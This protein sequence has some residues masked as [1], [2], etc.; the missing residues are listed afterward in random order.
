MPHANKLHGMKKQRLNR[1]SSIGLLVLIGLAAAWVIARAIAPH[2]REPNATEAPALTQFG[3]YRPDMSLREAFDSLPPAGGDEVGLS[4][5]PENQRSW[6]ARWQMLAE[7]RQS[8]DISY[9]ILREDIFG[10]AFLGHLLR[11]AK[12]GLHVRLLL[13]RQGTVMSFTSKLGLDWLDTLANTRRIDIKVF[14][15]LTDRYLQA[16]AT[17]NPI[18]AVASEHDKIMVCDHAVGMIGGRN[19][20]A[21]YF[22][23]PADDEAAFEDVD[24]ILR[25]RSVARGLTTAFETQFKSESARSIEP[26]TL[27]LE[28]FEEHLLL[29]YEAMDAWLNA[30]PLDA[31]FV[32]R[33]EALHLSWLDDLKKLPRLRGSRTQSLPVEVNAAIRLLD[34]NTR[35]SA[36]P[37]KIA[38][39]LTRLVQSARA[40][41]LIQSPY[42]VLSNEA[43]DVLAQAAKRGVAIT[44]YTNSPISSDNAW[45]Q[46]FFLEQWPELLARVDGLRLFVTGATHTLHAKLMVF[47]DNVAVVG[48]YNLD[49]ISMGINSEIM[50][51]IWS[52]RFAKHVAQRPRARLAAGAPTVYEYNIK[53]DNRGRALRD[54][55]GRPI[56]IFGPE[57]HAPPDQWRK[58]RAYWMVLRAAE[59]IPGFSPL[60]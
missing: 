12:Q 53:R 26:E 33:I 2:P 28:S 14:R 44:I 51:A 54:D 57:N 50:A 4:L 48:T 36:G 5:L 49:P 60:F 16:F 30:T 34:S 29:A 23:H 27:D 21:E 43:I 8:I 32:R 40:R 1:V 45:S 11:K 13:D 42:L 58:V 9:F 19:I 25:G 17:A 22:A 38:Q 15:P 47:D 41:I 46:A 56:V 7:A 24:V 3:P 18:A 55:A 35:L 37:D 20:S 52:Q 6:V 39:G 59:K 31:A 10:A